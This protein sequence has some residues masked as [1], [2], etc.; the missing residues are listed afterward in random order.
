MKIRVPKYFNEFKCIADKCEDTCCAGWEVVID[1][2]AYEA[3]QKV[4]GSFGDRLRNEIINDGE[5][6]I[7]VLK[8]NNCPFLNGSK[9]CD[10]YA[11]LGEEYLC[12]TCQQFP[13]YTEEFGNLR[14]VGISLSCPEAARIMLGTSEKVE[15]EVTEN[16]EFIISDDDIDG[17]LYMEL[18]Q[19][20]SIVFSI[21]QNRNLDLNTRAALVLSFI[22]E[23]QGKIDEYELGDLKAI[24]QRYLDKT[25]I[26][27]AV[28]GLE[29]CKVDKTHR[30]NRI[31]E[32]F[33]VLK[34]L[35]HINNND[36][37]CLDNALLYFGGDGQYRKLYLEKHDEFIKYYEDKMYKF[38]N[39]L[40]YFVFRYFMKAVFD[41]GA[42]AKIKIAII[43]YLMIK[44]L[45][46]IRW[47][48]KGELADE[49]IVDI[50]HTYSKDVEHLVENIDTLEEEFDTNDIFAAGNIIAVLVSE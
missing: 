31:N 16:D 19:C 30:A 42:A 18:M 50:S 47:L 27:K 26:I 10:I 36:P 29:E 12:H 25:F 21:L 7:F 46:I 48:E 13:R 39:I 28:A 37:L 23:V 44:E 45:C 17:M 34:I 32:Y 3:Y 20:R 41:E 49:N 8:N 5:D 40:V 22:E 15:F 4:K 43:S 2:E 11:E 9:L 6:N 24:K 1:D 35:N 33:Q 38:E 14:E